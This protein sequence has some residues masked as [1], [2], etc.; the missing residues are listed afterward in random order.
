M[1]EETAQEARA[2]VSIYPEEARGQ[3]GDGGRKG[4]GQLEPQQRQEGRLL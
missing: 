1:Q 2:D 3:G 4:R